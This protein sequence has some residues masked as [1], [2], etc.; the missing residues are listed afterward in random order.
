MS[1]RSVVWM[2]VWIL[3]AELEATA[4]TAQPSMQGIERLIKK[5]LAR[6]NEQKKND[7]AF[8]EHYAWYRVRTIQEFNSKGQVTRTNQFKQDFYPRST[9]HGISE[10]TPSQSSTNQV[11]YRESDFTLSQELLDRFAFRLSGR[12]TM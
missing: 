6:A 8:R 12:D 7:Q 10:S 9:E 4:A 3:A 2:L 5:M 11:S 1:S